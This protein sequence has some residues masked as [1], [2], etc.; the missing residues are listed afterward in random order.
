MT[1]VLVNS[2]ENIMKAMAEVAIAYWIGKVWHKDGTARHC[3]LV[4]Y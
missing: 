2:I 3:L 1:V 4:N